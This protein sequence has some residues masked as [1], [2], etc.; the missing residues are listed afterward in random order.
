MP[1]VVERGQR[2]GGKGP[3]PRDTLAVLE[4]RAPALLG[5]HA[6][7]LAFHEGDEVI[8]LSQQRVDGALECRLYIGEA[9]GELRT[10]LHEGSSAFE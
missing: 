8:H 4:H 10:C 2:Q 1:A 3:Y 6:H 5:H 7:E 9:L